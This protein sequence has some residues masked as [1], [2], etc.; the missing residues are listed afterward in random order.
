[1]KIP[2]IDLFLIAPEIV[3]TIFGFLVLLVDVFSPKGEKKGYLGILS[4]IGI[5]IA[6]IFTLTQMGSAKSG[7]EG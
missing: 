6:F 4:L 5:L 3:I 1:M 2:E 7:F